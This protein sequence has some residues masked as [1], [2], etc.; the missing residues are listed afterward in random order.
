MVHVSLPATGGTRTRAY[1]RKC[2]VRYRRTTLDDSS[3]LVGLGSMVEFTSRTM[4]LSRKLLG[5][6]LILWMQ[7]IALKSNT[8]HNNV[9]RSG[10]GGGE[11]RMY[12]KHS[13]FR[14]TRVVVVA[15]TW[16]VHKKEKVYDSSFIV[17]TRFTQKPCI[18]DCKPAVS[19]IRC[20]GRKELK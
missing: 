17:Q 19:L 8:I 7:P 15:S 13:S 9:Q 1:A 16:F 3:M 20:I 14:V 4:I 5:L 2:G 6:H 11:R 10:G 18:S 12:G